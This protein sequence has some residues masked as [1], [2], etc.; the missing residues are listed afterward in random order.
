MQEAA[1]RRKPAAVFLLLSA[2]AASSALRVPFAGNS[3]MPTVQPLD[4]KIDPLKCMG[5]WYAASAARGL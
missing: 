3:K 4:R 1:A 2:L 5:D